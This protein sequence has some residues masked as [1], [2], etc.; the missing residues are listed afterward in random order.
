MIAAFVE[1]VFAGFIQPRASVRRLLEGG[2]GIDAALLMVVLGYL[3]SA[4]FTLLVPG[5]RTQIDGF[6]LSLHLIGVLLAFASFLVISLLIYGIG[7]FFG[8]TGTPRETLLTMGWY[9]VVTSVIEPMTL[10]ARIH[11]AE[12]VDAAGGVPGGQ[13]HIPDGALLM[14]I[15]A[16]GLMLWLMASF[17]AELHRF[18]RTWNVLA[19]MLGVSAVIS[20]AVMVLAPGA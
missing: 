7:R 15:F 14:F 18:G 17:V 10:P 11:L 2:H 5:A 3:L 8:G 6:P 19:V 1:N 4:I 13:V 20:A 9:S 12:A 16:S